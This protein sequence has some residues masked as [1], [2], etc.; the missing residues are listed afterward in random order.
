MQ[1]IKRERDSHWYRPDGTPC[2]EVPYAGKRGENGE[3]RATTLRDARKLG[4]FPSVTNVLSVKGK[5]GLENWKLEQAILSALTLPRSDGESE[6]EFALRVVEDMNRQA[7][8]A[9]ALGTKIHEQI[10]AW[11]LEGSFSGT[12]GEILHLA[13]PYES[14]ARA[15]L[16][17]IVAAEEKVVSTSVGYA[18]RL[19]LRARL[20]DDPSRIAVIDIKT[21]D[22]ANKKK[23]AFYPEWAMQLAGYGDCDGIRGDAAPMP[24]LIS[25]IIR[26]DKPDDPIMH[27]WEDPLDAL[28][29][30]HACFRLWCW[31]RKYVPTAA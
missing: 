12:T 7:A 3:M 8:D 9:A 27:E 14:W 15:N 22:L 28:D 29:A 16:A 2:H 24:R 10:E 17:E 13:E 11:N 4:L 5:S 23:P 1:F 30:F 31:D 21:Q 18:G 6:D 25:L 19:D 26:R 20:K